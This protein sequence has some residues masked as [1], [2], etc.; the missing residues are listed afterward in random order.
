M[1]LPLSRGKLA[2]V[3]EMTGAESAKHRPTSI[4]RRTELLW[5]IVIV[6]VGGLLRLGWPG[7]TE[8]K[9]DEARLLTLAL[10][11]VEGIG[12]PL[13][14]IDSSVGV[15]NPALSVWIYSLP[16]LAWKHVISATLFTGLLNTLAIIG[17]WWFAR[18]Y[19]GALAGLAAALMFAASPWAI[20]YSRKIWAQNLL[21]FFVVVWIVSAGLALVER[22]PRAIILHFVSLAILVQIHFSTVALVPASLLF[23]ILFRRR[24]RW[25]MVLIGGGLA[26][27]L[28]VPFL[29]YLVRD[30]GGLGTLTG[31]VQASEARTDLGGWRYTWLISTGQEIHS[32]AGAEAYEDYLTRVP[33]IGS[34]Q[35]V[36]GAMILV[37][38]GWLA[39]RALRRKGEQAA[40][41]GALVLIWALAPALV[42]TRHSFPLFPHY[43]IT[44]FPAQYIAAGVAV[45]ALGSRVRWMGWVLLGA[46]SAAQVGVWVALLVFLNTHGTPGGFGT[47]LR[48]Q[49]EAVELAKK[50]MVE[51]GAAEVLVAGTGEDPLV[52]ENAAVHAVLLRSISHR[53]VDVGHSAV[54]PAEPAVVL[55]H[56]SGGALAG[57]YL[58]ASS[59]IERVTLR[60][61]EGSIVIL[62][63]PSPGRPPASFSFTEP[64]Y[65]ANGVTLLGY[66]SPVELE[67]AIRWQI[68]W[69]TGTPSEADYH[70]FNHLL[71][72][73]GQRVSQ[74]DAP[75]FSARQWHAGD[76][77]ISRFT[78]SKPAGPAHS[79]SM[80]TGMYTYPA[81]EN[82]PVLDIAGNPCAD[83]VEVRL[84]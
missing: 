45:T 80:R 3:T 29:V 6:A 24:L 1:P 73:D 34:L 67:G 62:A 18:R 23:L 35:T 72:S 51:E 27:V 79:L 30:A 39:W 71:R 31:A 14:G 83:G 56:P 81:V 43:F 4:P 41:A 44:T 60:E 75:A 76:E 25:R 49:L 26:I 13:R 82:V 69:Q 65:L 61:G 50:V 36:W 16:L 42:F 28:L 9:A 40:E 38:L 10:D 37:G 22:R 74:A 53:F 52:D 66:D 20:F 19:W 5:L 78:L 21:P 54:F 46:S 63:L 11:L 77:V 59:R 58:A 17:C 8:F 33:D 48:A 7:L 68:H 32:L 15:P 12:F 70:F 2:L 55:L 57:I 64:N 84:P 47:P